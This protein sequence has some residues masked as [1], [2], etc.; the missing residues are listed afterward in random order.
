MS[1]QSDLLENI[2]KA[3]KE[4]IQAKKSPVKPV[5]INVADLRNRIQTAKS[6]L[7]LKGLNVSAVLIGQRM[8]SQ[9]SAQ[10]P[11]M[12]ANQILS[13]IPSNARKN[14]I[15]FSNSVPSN[16]LNPNLPMSNYRRALQALRQNSQILNNSY[17]ITDNE[18]L[19]EALLLDETA[20]PPVTIMLRRKAIRL[21]PDGK[22]V[23]LYTND[24]LGLVFTVPYNSKGEVQP[25][26]A[27]M[28]SSS[29]EE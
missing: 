29:T 17:E 14:Y 5:R 16:A 28:P 9:L 4:K 7:G 18:Q 25:T 10:N 24:K 23:A 27:I 13:R 15:N 11:N 3:A 20:N 8:Y 21:F 1:T 12:Q 26:N 19:S 2:I 6:R 22:R